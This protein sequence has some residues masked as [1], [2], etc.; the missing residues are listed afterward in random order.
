MRIVYWND[1]TLWPTLSD[2]AAMLHL[3]KATLSRQA[4]QGN[5]VSQSLGLGRSKRVIPLWEVF[6]LGV[7]YRRRPLDDLKQDMAVYVAKRAH[8]DPETVAQD[9]AELDESMVAEGGSMK[10]RA[11]KN[12]AP[13][14]PEQASVSMLERVALFNRQYEGSYPGTAPFMD[15]GAAG[16][17]IYSGPYRDGTGDVT[18][19]DLGLD[20]AMFTPRR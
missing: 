3:N 5:V 15:D 12:T 17:V 20:P 6:R 7:V 19:Q 8:V 16:E 4:Q 13:P 9:L 18:L 11:F 10:G 2:A 1:I 14:T